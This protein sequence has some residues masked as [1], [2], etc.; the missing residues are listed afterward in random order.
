MAIQALVIS[1]VGQM[2]AGFKVRRNGEED[3]MTRDV[4]RIR[5]IGYF[6][7]DLTNPDRIEQVMVEIEQGT[8]RRPEFEMMFPKGRKMPRLYAAALFREGGEVLVE[9]WF[10]GIF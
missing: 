6:E 7:E 4:V 5:C 2:G 10:F 1:L 8:I 3:Y 9:G